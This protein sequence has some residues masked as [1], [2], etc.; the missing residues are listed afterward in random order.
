MTVDPRVRELLEQVLESERTPEEVCRDC[1]EL[2][3]EVRALLERLRALEKALGKLFPRPGSD[4]WRTL[5]EDVDTL[6]QRDR[7]QSEGE[8]S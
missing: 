1:P 2:L 6:L 3:P 8:S 5:W 7:D 4:E